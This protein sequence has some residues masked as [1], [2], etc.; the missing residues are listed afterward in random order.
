MKAI[1]IRDIENKVVGIARLEEIGELEFLKLQKE[2]IANQKTEK[3]IKEHNLF[4][5]D[6]AIEDIQHEIKKL[7]GEE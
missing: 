2:F 3:Q 5:I 6:K 4:L 1:V 7:K